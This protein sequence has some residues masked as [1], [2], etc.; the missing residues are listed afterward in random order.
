VKPTT[1]APPSLR[2]W[3]AGDHLAWFV[4]EAVAELD[5]GVY[6]AYRGDG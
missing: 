1:A 4:L 3:P 6:G 5:L 2:E